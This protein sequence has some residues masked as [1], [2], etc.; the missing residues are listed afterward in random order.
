MA[1]FRLSPK[2]QKDI[3]EISDF[4]RR[5]NPVR[6]RSFAQELR[7]KIAATAQNPL[8]YRERAELK[9]GVRAVR[10]GQYL[11]LF[12]F[13]GHCLEVLTIQHGA[14]DIGGLFEEG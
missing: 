2:A 12:R 11:I 3:R 1:R 5:D 6:A 10:H 8:L 13:D 7:A 9:T 14:R 4:I